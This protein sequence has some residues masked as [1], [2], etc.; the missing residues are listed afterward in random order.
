MVYGQRKLSH[1]A[2]SNVLITPEEHRKYVET[3]GVRLTNE[4]MASES[5]EKIKAIRLG[6]RE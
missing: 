4:L 3:E 1:I 2:K 5:F 6:Q